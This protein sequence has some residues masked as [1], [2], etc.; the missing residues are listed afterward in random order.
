MFQV[1]QGFKSVNPG[2]S[3]RS[4]A[5]LVQ[6]TLKQNHELKD[7]INNFLETCTSKQFKPFKT[8]LNEFL[9]EYTNLHHNLTQQNKSNNNNNPNNPTNARFSSSPNNPN[10]PSNPSNPANNSVSPSNPTKPPAGVTGGGGGIGVL[11]FPGGRENV[12][13]SIAN[14]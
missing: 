4:V 10:N 8:I 12:V 2:H 1:L 11:A 9:Q 13:F 14:V 5:V 3:D 7:N 6:D